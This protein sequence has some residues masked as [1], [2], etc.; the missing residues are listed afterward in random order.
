LSTGFGLRR[1]RFNVAPK[2]PAM[3]QIRTQ[4]LRRVQAE[5]RT[6]PPDVNDRRAP[7]TRRATYLRTS[8]IALTAALLG[9]VS[10]AAC[11]KSD[12]ATVAQA[13]LGPALPLTVSGAS[14]SVAAPSVD[15]LP[16]ARDVSIVRVE[17]PDDQYA[18]LDD[19]YYQSDAF[20]D[21]P[22]DYAFDYDGVRPWVW[23]SANDALQFAEPLGGG[24]R[25]YYYQPGAA[26]P[27]LVRD[28]GYSYGYDR[29][30]LAAI[31]DPQ[32][33]ALSAADMAARRD[34]AGRYLAR[35]D[36]LYRASRTAQRQ[37]VVA[38]NWAAGRAEIAAQRAQWSAER[39]RQNAWRSYDA[40]HAAQQA[41]A[42]QDERARRQQS[43]EAF[44]QWRRADY[45]GPAPAPALR[46]QAMRDNQVRQAQVQDEAARRVAADAQAQA[47]NQRRAEQDRQR[48]AADQQ[49]QQADQA[50]QQADNQR[51][52]DQNHAEADNQRRAQ[53]Q[54]RQQADQA[55][56]QADNQRRADQNHAQADNQRHAQDQQRRQAQQDQQNRQQADQ[57]RAQADI[58]HRADQARL[59]ADQAHAQAETQH[60]AEQARQQAAEQQKQLQA[61]QARAQADG[62]R[63]AQD[64]QRQQADNQ[65]RQ[66]A[67]Q[68]RQQAQQQAEQQ[69]Q[70]AQQQAQLAQQK[71][72]QAQQDQK[73]AEHAQQQAHKDDKG[74]AK[75]AGHDEHREKDHQGG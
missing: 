62:Q 30:Q 33:R 61:D 24:Y 37:S 22:P 35:A 59:Q 75:P 17:N 65:R 63:K 31:Y 39:S 67:E 9:A 27:Y 40:A 56:Q 50:R 45:Q 38:A 2:A 19:A 4:P 14:P 7:M 47:D 23:R 74:Q 66:Q 48:Q 69:K 60:R 16:A 46:Q 8:A 6:L 42:W 55:R 20:G 34:Y 12:D 41:A 21:A 43:A 26:Y 49:R 73:K 25:Y 36:S 29:G 58:Q 11:N 3:N 5:R 54:Q 68:Q 18:Y 70:Q 51:R 64:E 44:S 57:A 72:K 10:L 28:N 13:Q 15:A 1:Q 32:G 53:D 52:A 71:G